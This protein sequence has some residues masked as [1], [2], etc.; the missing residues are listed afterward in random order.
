MTDPT[1]AQASPHSSF[2]CGGCGARVEYAPGTNVL[3]CPYCGYQQQVAQTGQQVREHAIEELATLPRKPVARIAPYVFVCQKCGASTQST[4]LS[5]S[6]QFCGA[7]LVA[8]ANAGDQIAPEA[9]LPFALDRSGAREAL[10]SWT[11]SRWFAPSGLKKVTEAESTK[12]TYLPHWTYDSQTVSQY[13][14][15]RGEHY[16]VT[17]NYTTTDSNGNTQTRTRQ[18]QRTRWYPVSGTVRRGFDDVLVVATRHVTN[19]QLYKLTPWP[20]KYAAPYQ[21]AYLAGY[22]T[23]R[24]DTEPEAGL[25]VAKNQMAYTIREDCKRDIGGDEQQVHAVQTSYFNVTYKLMLL[26]VWIACYLYAGKNFQVLINGC[27]GL[28]VGERPYS[29]G[30]IVAAIAGACALIAAI[31][32]LI[33]LL[34]H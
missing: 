18:V 32:A 3:R 6:C 5:G 7:P 33:V 27:T 13:Q 17:E 31:I 34:R 10:K 12:G 1:M 19:E 23:L 16:Y 25:V 26:P 14:G 2:P 30:K 24:Y 8:D 22:D 28:V 9:V 20:L 29:T 21:P 15:Q 4:A 11:S